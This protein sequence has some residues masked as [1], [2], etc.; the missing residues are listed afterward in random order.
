VP[1][2]ITNRRL[3]AGSG[4]V[5][6]CVTDN[7]NDNN[8]YNNND[9]N[10]FQ[11]IA[12]TSSAN[13]A[14]KTGTVSF[15]DATPG[16]SVAMTSPLEQTYQHGH[17]VDT[18]L[19]D[20]L[21]R[22]VKILDSSWDTGTNYTSAINPWSLF[23]NNNP[24][25]NRLQGYRFVRGHLTVRVVVTG[26]PFLFGRM[27]VGYQPWGDR[28]V[29]R[30]GGLGNSVQRVFKL[31]ISQM[32]HFELDASTSQGG[33]MVLPFFSPYNWLDLTAENMS[34]DMG[35][36]YFTNLT[37]LRHANSPAGTLSF[38]VYAWMNDAEI[39]VPTASAYD[40]VT[41]QGMG[42]EFKNGLISKPAT[43][44]ARAAGLL[45]KIPVFRPYALATEMAASAVAGAASAFGY[46]RPQIVENICSQRHRLGGELATT[47]THEIVG[48]LALDAKSQLTLDPRTVGLDGKDEMSFKYIVG[49]ESLLNN[50]FWNE[51]APVGTRLW[52]N[53]VTP[54]FHCLDTTTTPPR[55]G[56]PPCTAVGYL[57]HSWRG[58]MVFR[59]S[60]VASAMHRGKLR[61]SYEPTATTDV[62]SVTEVYSRIIDLAETRDVEIPVHWHQPTPWQKVQ[63]SG[64]GT[65]STHYSDATPILPDYAAESFNGV[66]TIEVLTPLT[67]PDPSLAHSLSVLV[68]VR[69]GDDLEFANP[70]TTMPGF[71]YRSISAL[72]TP[73]GVVD[74]L[75]AGETEVPAGGAAEVLD[76][77]GT[78]AGT[79]TDP[80]THVF[81][82]ET[83]VSLRS[84]LRRYR[85]PAAHPSMP[86]V[87]YPNFIENYARF[88]VDPIQMC[89]LEYVMPWYVGWRGSMRFR[90]FAHTEAALTIAERGYTH[91]TAFF[92][93]GMSGAYANAGATE[94]E[95]PFYSN[96]RFALTRTSPFWQ[97]D[98]DTETISPNK[99]VVRFQN[100]T[101]T[102]AVVPSLRFQST[103]EDFSLF[104]FLGIPPIF[105]NI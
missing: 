51:A 49:R 28:S 30:D 2:Q 99:A 25:R 93:N 42:D 6:R 75:G 33:E 9:N 96:K 71:S 35:T 91:E 61:I 52:T 29:W 36:L 44:V 77:M 82:G 45:S 104:F 58:T 86:D 17:T 68:Y 89:F 24:I 5:H 22:P 10:T 57:F 70:I 101:T 97:M 94:T 95:L 31:Q 8:N 12:S 84:L 81:H 54:M 76:P 11:H 41:Y 85:A 65:V 73:Q 98:T 13:S 72:E 67:S 83:V 60:V 21:S 87:N 74:D 92:S 3:H 20:F 59:F 62:G 69:G 38:S 18:P 40:S 88:N 26:N 78:N 1:V 46:S 56:I 15:A 32:P 37:P 50:F 103:G 79:L 19:S 47:N 64:L 16:S 105:V 53:Y 23:L 55:N 48:R 39:A 4:N 43:A 100:I 102:S 63:P 7:N 80:L 27:L 34:K 90:N 14:V 66:V